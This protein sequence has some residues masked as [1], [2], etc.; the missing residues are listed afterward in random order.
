MAQEVAS[1][2]F[3]TMIQFNVTVQIGSY[4]RNTKPLLVSSSEDDDGLKL[5]A[6]NLNANIV[7]FIWLPPIQRMKRSEF[8][9]QFGNSKW[10]WHNARG[11][12][13]LQNFS[14]KRKKPKPNN[15]LLYRVK[16]NQ[17]FQFQI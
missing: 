8:A 5:A 4:S 3:P 12:L 10:S 17:L 9:L 15:H 13:E 6:C 7:S 1:W 2:D 14:L 16:I 11:M